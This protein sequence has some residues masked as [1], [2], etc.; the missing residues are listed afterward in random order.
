MNATMIDAETGEVLARVSTPFMTRYNYRPSEGEKT[1]GESLTDTSL[2]QPL[3]EVVER[4]ERAGMLRQLLDGANSL[5]FDSDKEISDEV[6]DNVDF[7]TGDLFTDVNRC[8]DALLTAVDERLAS[9]ATPVPADSSEATD[10]QEK[11]V[12]DDDTGS[13]EEN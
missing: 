2:Y 11:T 1:V 3:K 4:C 6:L 13:E 7:Q 12:S 8:V 9:S 5:R 10:G